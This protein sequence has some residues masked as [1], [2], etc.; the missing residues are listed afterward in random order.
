VTRNSTRLYISVFTV[1]GIVLSITLYLQ[2]Q[3]IKQQNSRLYLHPFAVSNAVKKVQV[4]LLLTTSANNQNADSIASLTKEIQRDLATIVDSYLGRH[5]DIDKAHNAI[6]TWLENPKDIGHQDS[7]AIHAALDRIHTNASKKAKELYERSE[8]TRTSFFITTLLFVTYLLASISF[9]YR[10]KIDKETTLNRKLLNSRKRFEHLLNYTPNAVIIATQDGCVID[11]STQAPKL[12]DYTQAELKDLHIV[13]IIPSIH[14]RPDNEQAK[15]TTPLATDSWNKTYAQ[16]ERHTQATLKNGTQIDISLNV[17]IAAIDDDVI[18]LASIRDI[19][20]EIADKNKIFHQANYDFLT[21]LPNRSLAID[22]FEQLKALAERNNE[23]IAVMFIDLDDFK[24]INDTLGHEMGDKLL[25]KLSTRISHH[26]RQE[27]TVAR[28]GGDE[29]IVLLRSDEPPAFFEQKAKEILSL[30]KREFEIDNRKLNISGSI[31]I[32][33][34]PENGRNYSV[35]LRKADS[36][37]YHS[38]A[39]GFNHYSFF[40]DCMSV[41]VSRR[42]ALEEE[43]LGALDH[44]EFIVFFQPQFDI[45]SGRIIG[46]EALCRWDNKRLGHVPPDEFIPIAEYNGEIINIGRY[47]ITKSI[48]FARHIADNYNLETFKISVNLSPRQ[49]S[50]DGLILF[51]K[52]ALET[53]HFPPQQLTLEVTEGA[54]IDND[55]Q[56][57]RIFKT[58]ADASIELSM[59]DFGT[60]YS[61]LSHLRKYPFDHIKLDKTFVADITTST[62][63]LLSAAIAMAHALNLKVVAEGVETE[64]QLDELRELSCEFAQGYLFSPALEANNF[65]DFVEAYL[66]SG[67]KYAEYPLGV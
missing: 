21:Q 45:K 18:I 35:L 6:D 41:E 3:S 53:N 31:G 8:S 26:L 28:L 57:I 12:F 7:V 20:E 38:K 47:V 52:Q 37:M 61:S 64:A 36:A 27:D 1:I 59:D 63:E 58:L 24:K 42:F 60:G 23:H 33:L 49:F 66:A 10:A 25:K 48:A 5:K 2:I 50:D 29:F 19:R 22:R 55:G 32:A 11:A 15:S 17:N 14:R 13:D 30:I 9:L 56:A 16:H 43:M 4:N 54:L 67:P 46:A 40:L 62:Q 51:I 39:L 65:C 34:F 44:N